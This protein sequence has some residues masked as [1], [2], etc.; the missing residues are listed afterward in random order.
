MGLF[1]SIAQAKLDAF[2]QSQA[3]I[4]FEPDGTIITANA[5]FLAAMGYR[6]DEV[7]GKHHSLFIEPG[8]R[9]T[10]AYS[11]FWQ[12]L[13]NGEF[14]S[15]EFRRVVKGGREVWIQGAYNPIPGRDGRPV[16]V[17]KVATE[18]TEIKRRNADNEGKINA[19]NRAQA[20]ILFSLDGTVL[21]ANENFLKATGYR[22]EEIRGKHHSLFVE[23]SERDSEA[24]GRFW[25]NLREG[26][27]QS[28]E[29]KR[30]GKGGKPVWLQANYSPILDPF[31]KPFKVV[32]FAVDLTSQ[33]EERQR[34]A[35]IQRQIDVD[36]GEITEAITALNTEATT[37]ASASAQTSE[38]VQSVASGA[39]QLVA[40]V[41]EIS[42][43]LSH[44]LAISSTAVDQANRTTDVMTGLA[45]A[46]ERIGAVVKLINDIAGQTN[47]LA[48]NATIEAARAGDAGKGFA[49]VASEVKSL[50]T[51]TARATGEIRSQIIAV[52]ESTREAVAAISGITRTITEINDIS[53]SI[54]AAVEEQSAVTADIAHNM[55]TASQ[56]VETV[57]QNLGTISGATSQID[58]AAQSVRK[59]LQAI[60]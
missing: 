59:S 35:G 11:Q 36:L 9:E 8:E 52:Q 1:H 31:G 21:E 51:Q 53:A 50:A 15:G 26:Q 18:I 47:L 6:L 39:E 19:I 44:A 5:N 4:E 12:A 48:L 24:Y 14:Q 49:V 29:Y 38:N 16:R 17:V 25:A 37:A 34:R 3:I 10:P 54:A 30:I 23:P 60:A 40:S 22:I 33:V 32:K 28:G 58:I 43:Q 41:E 27:F 42:R 55:Q 46:A 2:G 13:A 57:T 20:V 7:V 56:G 45:V